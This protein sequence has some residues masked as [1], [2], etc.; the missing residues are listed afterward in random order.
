MLD[1][2]IGTIVWQPVVTVSSN[3]GTTIMHTHFNILIPPSYKLRSN[4]M[5]TVS[6]MYSNVIITAWQAAFE[7]T[8]QN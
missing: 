1:A 4:H 5:P 3:A 2:E 7:K 8:D 6:L